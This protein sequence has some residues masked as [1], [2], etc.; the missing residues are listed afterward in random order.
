MIAKFFS[1]IIKIL[2]KGIGS[3]LNLLGSVLPTSA[4]PNLTVASDYLNT[5]WEH[6]FSAFS[7]VCNALSIPPQALGIIIEIMAL[8]Y[9]TKPIISLVKIVINW[10]WGAKDN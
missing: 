10:I 5:F 9:I 3:F 6:I 1:F 2:S 7:W 8:K 4:M